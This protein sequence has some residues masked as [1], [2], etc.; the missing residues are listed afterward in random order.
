MDLLIRVAQN[1]YSGNCAGGTKRI[2]GR[3][4]C[5]NVKEIHVQPWA[6]NITFELSEAK[7]HP[8]SYPRLVITALHILILYRKVD[9]R[10]QTLKV[11]TRAVDCC[12]GLRRLG[13]CSQ[14]KQ[15]Q[16]RNQPLA[17]FHTRK[18]S[19]MLGRQL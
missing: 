10:A 9:C 17:V 5:L 12:Y 3:V 11:E 8:G 6:C 13:I 15:L 19:P 18:H 16:P 7:Q 14:E 2:K 1:A 4:D